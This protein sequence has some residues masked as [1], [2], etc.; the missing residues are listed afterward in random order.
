MRFNINLATQP[1][2]DVQRFFV[3]WGLALFAIVLLT[4]GLVYAAANAFFSWRRVDSDIRYVRAQIAERDREKATAE[5]VLAR[6]ENRD[7]RDRSRFLN[8]LIA[9]KAFSWT[10]VFTDMEKIMPP[11]LRMVSMRPTVN[12]QDQLE[13]VLTVGGTSRDGA[14][15]LVRR[16]EE[17][18]HF[19]RAEILK[20]SEAATVQ[21][22]DPI[23][24]EISAIYVPPF[25]QR[26]MA[27]A[28]GETAAK[29]SAEASADSKQKGGAVNVPSNNQAQGPPAGEPKP[30]KEAR[31]V[32]R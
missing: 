13:L 24:F 29:G 28:E 7:T 16:L 25:A 32:G 12:D 17:S 18:P 31:N 26:R 11:R 19:M 6:P 8:S 3:R 23:H 14:I 4:G 27:V 15:Q 9:R 22:G 30:R 5:A 1:Y 2:E 21:G 20:E 10:D